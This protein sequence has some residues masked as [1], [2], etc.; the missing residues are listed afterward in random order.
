M[1]RPWEMK[2]PLDLITSAFAYVRWLG[3]R[4]QI[5]TMTTVWDKSIVDRT[6][7]LIDWVKLCRQIVAER[8]VKHLFLFGKSFSQRLVVGSIAVV[9][10]QYKYGSVL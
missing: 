4:K 8:K 3:N 10:F 9:G 6:A 5:E 1:P 2:K 7:D